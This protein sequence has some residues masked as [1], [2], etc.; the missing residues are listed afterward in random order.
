MKVH[1]LDIDSSER[2]PILYPDPGDYVI[3]LNNPVYNVSKITIIS[4]KIRNS[5]LLINDRNN[6]FTINTA[7]ASET[8]VIPIGNYTG[9]ELAAAVVQQSGIVDSATYD[10]DTNTITYSNANSSNFTFAFYG[11][12]N[13]Y[14]DSNNEYTTPHDVLGFVGSNIHSASY[15]LQSGNMNL[16]GIDAFVLKLSSGSNEF[17]KTVYSSTPFYTG[18]IL[19][20]GD[21][22]NYSGNDDAVEYNFDSGVLQTI[23]SIRV[24]FYYSSHGRLIP[25]D[26]RNANH[27]LKLGLT[28]STDKLENVPKIEKDFS[29]P[30][31]V[32]IPEFEDVNRWDAFVSIFIIVFVGVLLM[33]IIKR[34]V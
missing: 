22:I 13:G 23:S 20:S 21:I 19:A 11:G 34:R 25:Y 2:D 32:H 12:E 18:K 29:L 3:H 31:P 30:P 28:C 6:R 15:N 16:Q 7:S 1:T 26:F 8:V 5:Q 17:N 9:A 33:L 24:Q 4:A 27:I 10:S 14:T